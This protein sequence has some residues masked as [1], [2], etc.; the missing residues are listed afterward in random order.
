MIYSDEDRKLALYV[1]SKVG[2]ASEAARIVGCS[3][4]TIGAWA[5]KAGV[6]RRTRKSPV[7]LSFSEKLSF[8]CRLSAGERACDL[9]AEA[10]VTT[11]A[12][13]HWRCELKRKGILGIMSKKEIPKKIEEPPDNSDEI[14]ELKAQ[15]HKLELKVAV[16]EGTLEILKKDPGAETSVLTNLESSALVNSLKTKFALDELLECVGLARSSYYRACA[17][18]L[19]S[20]PIGWLKP[21]VACIF[22]D[23][24][25]RYGSQRIWQKIRE[26]GLVVSEKLVRRAMRELNLHARSSN[27]RAKK[28][29]SYVAGLPGEAPNLLL[30]DSARDVHDFTASEPNKRIVSDITE[31]KLDGC[32]VYLS[33]MVDLY[34]GRVVARRAATSPSAALACKTLEDALS[35]I[36]GGFVFHSDRGMHYRTNEWLELC[37]KNK[38]IRS[39]SRK[40]HSPDNAAMEGFFGRLKVEFFKGQSWSGWSA[41]AFIEELYRYIDWYNSGRLKA[42]RTNG[43]R[44]YDTIDNR[45]RRLGLAV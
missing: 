1:L 6:L 25:G 32:K 2:S 7:Q 4:S 22:E 21:L 9:A 24:R 38:I 3:I 40:G 44:I 36:G 26:K 10:N 20:D 31:F 19:V 37:R 29:S 14:K 16:L 11:A 15:N 23:T 35:K 12:I 33:A 43:S 8:L 30:V 5:D 45:R 34:D 18:S 42:F 17:G 28:Y 13:Y 39:M 27:V 41:K